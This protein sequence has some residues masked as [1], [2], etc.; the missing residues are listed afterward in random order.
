MNIFDW[1]NATTA[2]ALTSFRIVMS[3]VVTF[4]AAW[5]PS[6]G[7]GYTLTKVIGAAF[8]AAILLVVIWGGIEGIK[9]AVAPILPNNG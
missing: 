8:L 7:N 1:I 9:D 2:E 3:A 4:L 5:L 6:R